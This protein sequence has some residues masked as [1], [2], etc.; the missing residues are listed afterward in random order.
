MLGNINNIQHQQPVEEIQPASSQ[1]TPLTQGKTALTP[2]KGAASLE[3]EGM[4]SVSMPKVS[5]QMQLPENKGMQRGRFS[6]LKGAWTELLKGE[7]SDNTVGTHQS[8]KSGKPGIVASI[9]GVQKKSS[10]SLGSLMM[11]DRTNATLLR[12]VASPVT[13]DSKGRLELGAGITDSVKTLLQQTLGKHDQP[14]I[15]AYSSPD[16]LQHVLM[17]KSGNLFSLQQHDN[18][19]TA[20][21]SSQPSEAKYALDQKL[22]KKGGTFALQVDK[23]SAQITLQV[24]PRSGVPV[25]LQETLSLP[26]KLHHSLLTGIYQQPE[27]ASQGGGESLRLHENTL[28]A[29]NDVTGEWQ[30]KNDE[31]YNHLSRQ[32]DGNLYAIKDVHTLRNLSDGEESVKFDDKIKSYAAN[33]QGQ[34]A[35]LTAKEIGLPQLRLLRSTSAPPDLHQSIKFKLEGTQALERGS[36]HVNATA[37]GLAEQ[38][39]FIADDKGDVFTGSLPQAGDHMV[40]LQ[41]HVSVDLDALLGVDHKVQGFVNDEQGKIHAQVSDATGQKH[42]APMGDNPQA[43]FKPGWNL[44]DSLTVDNKKGLD[45]ASPPAHEMLD[46]GRLGTMALHE[47]KVHYMDNTTQ[48]WTKTDVGASQLKRGLDNQAYVLDGGQVKKLSINQQADSVQHG[49]NNVFA[50]SQARNTPSAGEALPGLEKDSGVISM[51]VINANKYISANSKGEL[52]LHQLKPGMDRIAVPSQSLPTAGLEGDVKDLTLDKDHNLFALNKEGQIFTLA[53]HDWQGGAQ[54][55]STARWQP[56]ETPAEGKID[57]LGSTKNHE[58]LASTIDGSGHNLT[59]GGWKA[60][61]GGNQTTTAPQP[62]EAETV[63]NRLAD[64]TKTVRLPGTGVT[65][66]GSAQIF[67]KMSQESAKLESKFTDRVRAHVFGLIKETPENIG[68]SI[69]HHFTGREG[70]QPL[71]DTQASLFKQLESANAPYNRTKPPVAEDLKTKLDMLDLGEQG[72]ALHEELKSFHND[73]ET[74]SARSALMLGKHQ[75]LVKDDGRINHDFTPSAIKSLVQGIN[76]QRSGKNLSEALITAILVNP[77]SQN[78]KAI[79]LLKQ[80]VMKNVDMSYQSDKVAT[81]SHRDIHD[82]MALTKSRLVLDTLTVGD[83]HKVT[84]QLATLSGKNPTAADLQPMKDALTQLRDQ[85]YG[86]NEVKKV[87]DMGFTNFKTLEADY[88][89]IRSFAKA[90]QNENHAV[91]VTSRTALQA[92]SQKE[93]LQKMKDTILSLDNGE[94]LSFS[95]NYNGGLSTVYVPA[96]KSLPVPIVPGGGL[97]GDRTYNLSFTRSD[98]GIDVNF[99]RNGG[100]TAKASVGTGYQPID[101][102]KTV[103]LDKEHNLTFDLRAGASVAASAGSVSQNGLTFTLSEDELPEFIDSLSKGMLNPMTLAEKGTQHLVQEGF[104][105]RFNVDAGATLDGRAGVNL[106]NTGASPDS[107]TARASVGISVGS[108]LLSATHEHSTLRGEFTEEN[109]TTNN[110]A[111]FFN[112]ASVGANAGLYVGMVHSDKNGVWPIGTATGVSGTISVDAKTNHSITMQVKAAEPLQRKE[113][114]KLITSLGKAFS[115]PETAQVLKGI[116]ILTDT[117]EKLAILNKH[118][119]AKTPDDDTQYA[120]LQS[121]KQSTGQHETAKKQGIVLSASSYITT[122]TNLSKLDSNGILHALHRLVSDNLPPTNADRIKG[123]MNENPALK[124]VINHMQTLGNATASVTLELKDDVKAKVEKGIQENSLGKK[125][126]AGIFKDSNNLRIASI[127]LNQ[128]VSK[129]EGLTIPMPLLGGDSS[130]NV[131]MSKLLGK[132]NFSYGQNQETPR[133]YS[134]EGSI[135]KAAP[136]VANALHDL[137][138]ESIELAKN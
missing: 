121:L 8:E 134:L 9:S 125:D 39:I 79:S 5:Q 71:Y 24:Q 35:L 103:A 47:G 16:N 12:G 21:H 122:Y 83:L 62:R 86:G 18:G 58:V 128:T 67:G 96:L 77:P 109:S 45:Q 99:G 46:M 106:T 40:Q 34:V 85:Q 73:L 33:T 55:R 101:T 87:T 66:T 78:S 51:A 92:G 88:D 100:V 107:V 94:N 110:R 29:L 104:S 11:A 54:T 132:V 60:K 22:D 135:A 72:K 80:F 1:S 43:G 124:A 56:V 69:K 137:Q 89:A 138:K 31:S 13:L 111:R 41:R 14:F 25:K 102:Q 95:R 65:L 37:V 7:K 117:D 123:F 50:F 108:N 136:E 118:C 48:S 64:A 113:V 53:S 10:T 61:S 57:R 105:M 68:D 6:N 76:P 91:S 2:Q 38:K 90:F 27:T 44:S 131:S 112:Q 30:K 32:A 81:R 114:E 129:K 130:A 70:L 93:L 126:L 84:D 63:Y 116:N 42:L 82:P 74:S 17:D 98:N 115:D 75:G 133:N 119:A 120:A 127:E 20:L 4:H 59:P 15:A 3:K 19:F 28:F 36:E 52:Q 97:T 49:H 23:G 26:G